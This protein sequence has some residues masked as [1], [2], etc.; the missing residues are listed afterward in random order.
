MSNYDHSISVMGDSLTHNHTLGVGWDKFWTKWLQDSLRALG[1]TVVVRNFGKSG[2]TTT[3]MIVRYACMTQFAVPNIGIIFGGVNDPGNAISQATTQANI[4]T[5]IQNLLTAGT[6]K[7]IVVTPQF[8]NYTSGGD[9]TGVTPKTDT[10][11]NYATVIAAVKSAALS[12][13][14]V[15]CDLF[16][17]LR[18]RI[19]AGTDA[20]QSASWH[21]APT[22]Q[23]F[24]GYG[25]DLVAR[26]ILATIQA[27]NWVSAL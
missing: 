26:V 13:G 8:L 23:H 3:Q 1:C 2:N 10:T 14:V 12:K 11:C 6:S 9:F 21:D 17:Y 16:N 7:I 19:V 20:A 15:A 22:D 5:M 27:Q 4:E 18:D 24:N 25:H